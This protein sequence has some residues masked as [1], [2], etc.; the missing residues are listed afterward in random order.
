MTTGS[1]AP[2][3]VE[4][5]FENPERADGRISPDGTMLGYLAPEANRRTSG[6]APSTAPTTRP[7]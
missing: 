6:C 3:P 4:H 5:F 2:I 7:A 1:P